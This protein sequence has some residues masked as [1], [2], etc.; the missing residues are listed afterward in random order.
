M[1]TEQAAEKLGTT[2][3]Q[4]R[5]LIDG[6]KLLAKRKEGSKEWDVD[7]RSVAGYLRVRR[8]GRPRGTYSSDAARSKRYGDGTP[9][10]EAMR[11]YF[12]EKKR[13]ERAG[14]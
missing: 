9:K 1:T 13:Q 5:R 2:D 14:E 7:G 11:K 12:R 8:L 10:A 4:V 6:G 3:R